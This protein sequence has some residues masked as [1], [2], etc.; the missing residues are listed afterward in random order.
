MVSGLTRRTKWA[1]SAPANPAKKALTLNEAIQLWTT[2]AAYVSFAEDRKGPLECGKL[3]D[4][5]ILSND[6]YKV[7][8]KEINKIEV[9]KTFVGGKIVWNNRASA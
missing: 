1:N 5:V 6:P 2:N 4:F 9:E 3:A 8:A 7:S